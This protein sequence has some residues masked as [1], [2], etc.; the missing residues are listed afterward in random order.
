MVKTKNFSQIHTPTKIISLLREFTMQASNFFTLT[1]LGLPEVPVRLHSGNDD[2]VNRTVV[3]TFLG[4][5]EV[6]AACASSLRQRRYGK[7]DSRRYAIN[8][9]REHNE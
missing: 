9:Q 2:T 3:G 4:L 6:G 1:F 5:P 7:Q 8:R